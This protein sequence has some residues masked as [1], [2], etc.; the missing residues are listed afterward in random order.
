MRAKLEDASK[1][2]S[3]FP[4]EC[5]YLSPV[6]V[7]WALKKD[8]QA[9]KSDASTLKDMLVSQNGVAKVGEG[10]GSRITLKADLSLFDPRTID[11][12]CAEIGYTAALESHEYVTIQYESGYT[13]QNITDLCLET[14]GILLFWINHGAGEVTA[15]V[16]KGDLKEEDAKKAFAKRTVQV[17]GVTRSARRK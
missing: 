1:V 4:T 9:K 6:T 16:K 2:K 5:E 7:D 11:G 15:L 3:A 13:Y 8:P 17:K 12:I 14:K 10:S